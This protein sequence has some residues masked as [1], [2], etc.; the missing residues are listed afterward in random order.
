M[1][2]AVMRLYVTLAIVENVDA[3]ACD[4]PAALE[5]ALLEGVRAGAFT[6]LKMSSAKF[7]PQ[8]AT[9][10]AIVGESHLAL[11]AWPEERRLFVDIASCSTRESVG[12][13]LTA[14]VAYF[15]GATLGTVDERDLP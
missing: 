5:A 7:E 14:V 11:H 12:R 15:P 6:L 13:A 2:S 3:V 4:D 8:G 9:A 1:F 10:A